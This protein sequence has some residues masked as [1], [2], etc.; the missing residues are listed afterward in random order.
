MS[1]VSGGLIQA[2]DYNGF[3]STTTGGNVN[4]TWGTGT[5]DAGWG[6]TSLGTVS[7]GGTVTATQWASL[8]NTV[9]SMGSQTNT[10]LT[11]R[12]APTAG[13]TISV[14]SNLDT[15]IT[16]CYTN[17]GNAAASGTT[18]STWTGTSSETAITGGSG[19]GEW[20]ITF[21]HTVTFPSADQARYFWN[22]GGLVRLDMSKTSTGAS[23]DT[24]WNSFIS[25]VGA[26]FFSGRVNGAAQTIASTEYT[27]V[28]RVGG[29]GTPSPFLTTTGWYSLT[30]G[31]PA[32]TVFQLNGTG[33]PYSGNY[34]Q[35]TAAV[36]AGRTEFTLVTTWY[37]ASD[38]QPT[39]ISGGTET[40]S[41]YSSFGTAP[42][43]I[44][45]YVPPSTANL[46]NSWGTP[47]VAASVSSSFVPDLSATVYVVGGGGG[48]G[49]GDNGAGGGG[50]G[51][52]GGLITE[53]LTLGL[54]ESFAVVV[55]AG[56]A[57]GIS[58]SATAG[59]QG[60]DSSFDTS[61]VA[62][63]GGGGG[64][65]S[66]TAQTCPTASSVGSTGGGGGR[67]WSGCSTTSGQG[68]AGGTG[69]GSTPGSVTDAGGGG[70][71]GGASAAGSNGTATSALPSGQGGAGGAGTN[72]T[73][74]ATTL[75]YAGGGG[76]GGQLLG[77]AGA[78]G[79]GTGGDVNSQGT[80]GTAN[81]GGGGGGSGAGTSGQQTGSGGS[82][83]VVVRY[84]GTP[85]ATGGTIVE[86]GGYTY[87]SFASSGTFTVLDGDIII[88]EY[89][90]VGGGGAGGAWFGGG[91][92][93]GG[94]ISGN[95]A[96]LGTSSYTVSIG[97]GGSATGTGTKGTNSTLVGDDL[98]TI[99]AYGGGVGYTN[100]GG[101]TISNMSGG[102]GGGGQYSD[103]T[104]T[105]VRGTAVSGQG[106]VGGYGYNDS[107]NY[108][109]SGGGGGGAGGAGANA[110]RFVNPS[111][112][113][114]GDG[115]VGAQSS[116][117]GTATYYAGGGGG[118]ANS[119][120]FA[121][122][123]G[124]NGGGGGGGNS[125]VG[126]AGTANTGGGGG[127]AGGLNNASAGGSGIVII[128]YA[129]GSALYTGGSVST[130]SRPGY[131]VH[132]FTSS[133]SLTPI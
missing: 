121:G 97:A 101:A 103:F 124:G 80:A 30:G 70:G 10:T 25:T 87:H 50:G 129:G 93:A 109:E 19:V 102:S 79:A 26:L 52:A 84:S 75:M 126:S 20:T 55:G 67:L 29:S 133:G 32:T 69:G 122:G 114:G 34:V 13:Q 31:N 98:S 128:A 120:S 53:S 22:A 56:G 54:G 132:T 71:G 18:S 116:I 49:A 28:T 78:S 86:S 81:R 63:G 90:I 89:L 127:G 1:Y 45:R 118:G 33:S 21:T 15:D 35:V 85:T 113:A 130:S 36:N 117:T 76:A 17:R 44:C 108:D 12:T 131:V 100:N 38:S 123:G 64:N 7:A 37:Q 72:I 48:G 73:V 58:N 24:D 65:A 105:Y 14:F 4:A 16:N 42:T 92:G 77:G 23:N 5:G 43:V 27:G 125:G 57:G 46:T 8:V 119:G 59:V 82:G 51:G 74:G 2:T 3:V 106:Y 83:I 88:L 47:T 115:G 61:Y 91:G 6:Q 39:Q 94:L 9:N 41:P 112:K 96:T 11:S 68:Y 95:F 99:T 40:T 66:G 110:V 62:Y 104:S 60:S 111:S 107:S